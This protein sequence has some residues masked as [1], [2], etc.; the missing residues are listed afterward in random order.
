MYAV[1]ANAQN[2]QIFGAK[3]FDIESNF[4]TLLC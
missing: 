3:I 2:V 1:R 4:K